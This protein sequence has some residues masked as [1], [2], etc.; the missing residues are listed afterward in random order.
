MSAINPSQGLRRKYTLP[1][2]L[3]SSYFNSAPQP[4]SSRNRLSSYKM[5]DEILDGQP[6]APCMAVHSAFGIIRMRPIKLG[7]RFSLRNPFFWEKDALL[8]LSN[9]ETV[10]SRIPACIWDEI[11]GYL[12]DVYLH[13]CCIK[14]IPT[15]R[16]NVYHLALVDRAAEEGK[17]GSRAGSQRGLAHV[18]MFAAT[19]A[20]GQLPQLTSLRIDING[21]WTPGAI[22]QSVFLYLSTF[23]LITHLTL[24]D[25]TL[26]LISVLLRLERSGAIDID[27]RRCWEPP[28]IDSGVMRPVD[29]PHRFGM[30]MVLIADPALRMFELRYPVRWP[31]GAGRA[32]TP[33]L[34]ATNM[35]Q[36]PA[37]VRVE[38][39]SR[40]GRAQA[41]TC[42]EAVAAEEWKTEAAVQEK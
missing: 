1:L 38:T 4:A 10:A 13:A 40:T 23:H 30:S 16:R 19:F 34:T 26:L 7:P 12:E 11:L 36:N 6:A 32:A 8:P 14:T 21:E 17:D 5:L 27:R 37:N 31:R 42:S 35:K 20:G 22:P 2:S 41:M 39:H 24:E 28:P 9:S 3:V 15:P 29:A 33:E 18:D 25:I